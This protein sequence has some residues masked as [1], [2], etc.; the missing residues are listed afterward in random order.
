MPCHVSLLHDV[1]A[2]DTPFSADAAAADVTAAT[3]AAAGVT[4]AQPLSL[5]TR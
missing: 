3:P 2:I 1:F 4:A 5:F